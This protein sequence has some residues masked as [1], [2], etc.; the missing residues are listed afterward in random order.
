MLGFVRVAS[1]RQLHMG[2]QLNNAI[3][4]GGVH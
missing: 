2:K 4:T 3:E 1:Y